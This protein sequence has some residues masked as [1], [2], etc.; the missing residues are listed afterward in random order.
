MPRSRSVHSVKQQLLAKAREAALAAIQTYN[1]PLVRFKSETFIVL[2]VIAWTYLLHAYYR[3]IG[4]EYRHYHQ[5]ATRRRF[6][7]TKD[8]SYKY[9]ELVSCLECEQCPLDEPVR[10]NL[11]FLLGLRHEIEHHMP[12]RLDDEM[13]SRYQ[14]CCVNFNQYIKSLFGDRYGI[15]RFLSYSIQFVRLTPEQVTL[16]PGEDIPSNV[17]SYIARFDE[18]LTQDEFDSPQYALRFIFM[19]KLTGSKG[20]ADQ[21]IEFVPPDSPVA[22]AANKAYVVVKETEKPKY[23]PKQV[24]QK[25]N[26]EGYTWFGMGQHTELWKR[27]DARKEGTGYGTFVAG[28]EWYWYDKWVDEVRAYCRREAKR[29]ENDAKTTAYK[30]G[31]IIAMMRNEGFAR[32]NMQDH[33]ELWQGMNARREDSPF[34]ATL[35]DGKWYWNDRWVEAVREHCTGRGHWCEE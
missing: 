8:G 14:A 16:E 12:P 28:G 27:F 5:K 11:L 19:R 2:M 15:D 32:F 4:V 22:E 9:W 21:V 20:Q 1:N 33:T 25:V 7:R 35:S 23:R 3:S 10:K 31:Q 34:G 30:P 29:R 18:G 26:D 13:S 17:R 6:I 24:V